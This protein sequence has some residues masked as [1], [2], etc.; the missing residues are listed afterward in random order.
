[1]LEVSL[2]GD[3]TTSRAVENELIPR[4]QENR[5]WG[6]ESCVIRKLALEVTGKITAE[7]T[8]QWHILKKK[9]IAAQP[10]KSSSSKNVYNFTKSDFLLQ[11]QD[12]SIVG[13]TRTAKRS[14]LPHLP[15]IQTSHWQSTGLDA[16]RSASESNWPPETGI[17]F[18]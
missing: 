17:S 14:A 18:E 7:E 4:T 3:I 2:H 16:S 9:Q 15:T 11:S 5:A 8:L 1:V 6:R 12:P 10:E 13:L